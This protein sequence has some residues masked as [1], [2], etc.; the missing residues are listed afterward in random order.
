MVPEALDDLTP[1]E[2]HRVYRM[3][4][5]KVLVRPDGTLEGSGTLGSGQELGTSESTRTYETRKP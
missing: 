5:L 4:R 3:L 2:H 1:E